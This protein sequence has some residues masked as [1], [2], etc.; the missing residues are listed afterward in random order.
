MYLCWYDDS[1]KTPTAR[2]IAEGAQA[3]TQRFGVAPQ[4]CL[5]NAAEVCEVAGMDVRAAGHVR[6]FNFWLGIIVPGTR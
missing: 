1:A 5:V 3:Y 6:R 4:V 2:K